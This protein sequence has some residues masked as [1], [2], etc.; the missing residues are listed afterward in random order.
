MGTGIG[1]GIF[2]STEER[3]YRR[4]VGVLAIKSPCGQRSVQ[5]WKQYG[6]PKPAT[7]KFLVSRALYNRLFSSVHLQKSPRDLENCVWRTWLRNSLRMGET[8]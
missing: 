6:D 2:R 8:I 7:G 1:L 3:Q 4:S 5:P